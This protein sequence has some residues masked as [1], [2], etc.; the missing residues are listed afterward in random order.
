MRARNFTDIPR[1]MNEI[2]PWIVAIDAYDFADPDPLARLLRGP[3][4]IP[5]EVQPVLADIVA[6]SRPPNRKAA[7][8][9]KVPAAERMKVAGSVSVIAGLVDVLK[10]SDLNDS[11]GNPVQG[12]EMAAARDGVE[13]IDKIRKLEGVARKQIASA[14]RDFGVSVETIENLLRDLRQ[15]IEKFPTL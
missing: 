4:P 13:T 2:W 15:K 6:G 5:P 3:D 12:P 8:K 9:L 10:R 7:A 1:R 14:A 11:A